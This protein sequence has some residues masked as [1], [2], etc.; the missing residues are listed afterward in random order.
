MKRKKRRR[1]VQRT[2]AMTGQTVTEEVEEDDTSLDAPAGP[3]AQGA[4][5]AEPPPAPKPETPST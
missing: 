1:K 4:T 5:A 3:E 2:D